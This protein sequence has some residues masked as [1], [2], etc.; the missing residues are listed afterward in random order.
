MFEPQL[1]AMFGS[2][3]LC[4]FTHVTIMCFIPETMTLNSILV[5]SLEPFYSPYEYTEHDYTI[6][7]RIYFVKFRKA[8]ICMEFAGQCLVVWISVM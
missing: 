5:L 7:F 8:E 6:I 2:W 3:N 1:D 4:G